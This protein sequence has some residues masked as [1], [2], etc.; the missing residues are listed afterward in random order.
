M[1]QVLA[2]VDAI[3][4]VLAIGL[5]LG[6]G[7]PAMFAIGV[8]QQSEGRRAVAVVAFGV[9]GVGVIAGLAGIVAHGFGVKL[10]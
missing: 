1:S 4:K 9:V 6:A 5:V 10:L 7:L 8:R 2:G 3:W